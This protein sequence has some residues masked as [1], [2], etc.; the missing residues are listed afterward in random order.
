MKL[1]RLKWIP[2]DAPIALIPGSG[3]VQSA[4]L[5]LEEGEE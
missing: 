2:G 5:T 4:L 3:E 1:S